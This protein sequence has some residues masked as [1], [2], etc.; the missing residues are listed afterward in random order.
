MSV[1]LLHRGRDRFAHDAAR[2]V[3]GQ[4]RDRHAEFDL[5]GRALR[6]DAGAAFGQDGV[7]FALSVLAG[8]GNQGGALFKTLRLSPKADKAAWTGRPVC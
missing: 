2:Q 5:G 6:L 1:A 8:L 4:L 3:G 7:P